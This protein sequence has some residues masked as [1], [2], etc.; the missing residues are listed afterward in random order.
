M[1]QIQSILK[2][3][4]MYGI[5]KTTHKSGK[6]HGWSVHIKMK[7]GWARKHF[8]FL[9]NGGESAALQKAKAFRDS[10]LPN[11]TKIVSPSRAAG[12]LRPHD[13]GE[14]FNIHRGFPGRCR[15]KGWR[16]EVMLKGVKETKYFTDAKY[17]GYEES[18]KAA[19][20]YRD[21]LRSLLP[22]K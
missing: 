21:Y 13:A 17:G 2:T 15:Y 10:C 3:N 18:L 22:G 9:R 1:K 8:S 14:L 7:S 4:P 20:E 19:Q 11:S 6:Y 5:S 16:V 12:L